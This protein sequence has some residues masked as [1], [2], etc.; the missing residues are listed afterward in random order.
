MR[1][2]LNVWTNLVIGDSCCVTQNANL[3][4]QSIAN[5]SMY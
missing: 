5:D 1:Y 2:Q 3:T 4:V